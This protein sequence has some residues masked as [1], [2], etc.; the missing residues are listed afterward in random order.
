MRDS[1][2]EG[3][4]RRLAV[5]YTLIF[6]LGDSG[7][8]KVQKLTYFLQEAF[9]VP[10]QYKFRMYHYGPYS[11]EIERDLSV[12]RSLGYIDIVQDHA[13]F[14]FHIT[15]LVS[16][17]ESMFDNA[18][19]GFRKEVAEVIKLFKTCDASSLEL[20]ATIHFVGNILTVTSKQDIIE[21]VSILKPK[22]S[23]ETILEK[24]NYLVEVKLI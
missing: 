6:M 5:V 19:T 23:P 10:L 9:R 12:L 16:E 1:E 24:F 7:K 17:A 11:E 2:I 22:F 8:I 3:L 18:S 15:P 13:G 14:G 20:Y 21:K 4:L